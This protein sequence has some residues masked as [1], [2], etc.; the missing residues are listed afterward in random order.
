MTPEQFRRAQQGGVRK[1]RPGY[2]GMDEDDKGYA[3][4]GPN[5]SN[6]YPF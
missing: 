6:D 1:K 4:G 2:E 3:F 5:Y